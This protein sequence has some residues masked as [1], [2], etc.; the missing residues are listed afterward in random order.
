MKFINVCMLMLSCANFSLGLARHI[1][2]EIDDVLFEIKETESLKGVPGISS[3]GE[4][5]AAEYTSKYLKL[6]SSDKSYVDKNLDSIRV[7]FRD[8]LVPRLWKE[9][10][11][12]K[13]DNGAALKQALKIID[14]NTS[15][16]NPSRYIYHHAAKSGFD[17]EHE[18]A[19]M[20]PVKEAHE[21]VEAL[22][23]NGHTVYIFSNKNTNTMKSLISKY[24][25]LF[26]PFKSR[27]FISGAIKQLKPHIDSYDVILKQLEK[28]GVDRSEIVF[29]ESLTEY[30]EAAEKNFGIP[31]ILWSKD[32][33]EDVQQV[34]LG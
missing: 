2:F 34:L 26:V 29:I 20:Y 30:K 23:K 6:L 19:Y 27:I 7:L 17:P 25:N 15:R 1:I 4:K 5:M 28:S 8:N 9:F 10:F 32:E 24:K 13:I 22:C 3:L 11:L 18:I 12:D 16:L 14:G 31:A 33:V 21:L